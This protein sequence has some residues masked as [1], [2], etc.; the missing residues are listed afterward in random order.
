MARCGKRWMRRLVVGLTLVIGATVAGLELFA[1]YGLGLGDPPLSVADRDVEYLFRPGEYRRFG[2]RVYYNA[3]SMRSADVTPTK[4]DPRELRVLVLGDSVING[5]AQTDQ[6]QLATEALQRRLA[7]ELDRPVWVGN[8]SAGSWGPDNLLAYVRKFGWFE[9]DVA[10]VVVSS[11]DASDIA[12]FGPVV[13]VHPGFPDRRPWLA[14]EEAVLR[15]LPRYLPAAGGTKSA[16]DPGTES[17]LDLTEQAPAV[18]QSLKSLR[19]LI[20]SG[21]EARVAI[22]VIQ[23]ADREEAGDEWKPGHDWISFAVKEAGVDVWDV[24]SSFRAAME[25]GQSPYRDNIHPNPLG[26]KLLADVMYEV[27]SALLGR[28]PNSPSP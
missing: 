10:L 4:T 26:Q 14:L 21:R 24:R 2:N 11:H 19:Q 16:A 15:Y 18:Q 5:G 25:S 22:A 6:S 13:G 3:Y 20:E 28:T 27:V 23:H 8:V 9:A 7:G 1:R 17:A 12:T